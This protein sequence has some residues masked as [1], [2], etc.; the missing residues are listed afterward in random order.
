[1]ATTEIP[2]RETQHR[3][4]DIPP[5]EPGDCLDQPTFHERYA[6]MAEHVRAELVEGIVYMPSPAKCD[7][8]EGQSDVLGWLVYYKA[9]TDGTRSIDNATIILGEENELQPDGGLML[10]PECGGRA[11]LND[12]GYLVGGPELLAEIA[13]STAAYDLHAKRRAYERAGV[14]EYIVVV[15]RQRRVIWFVREHGRFME[16]QPAPDGILRSRFFP[17]LWLDSQ[18]LLEGRTR[19]VY[20]V[21]QQGLASPDHHEFVK[22]LAAARQP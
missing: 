10:L 13:S 11:R 3:F 1:M 2:T 7:H 8:G 21:L 20:E 4:D 17:G 19:R 6:A 16:L 5:L 18:A 22:K 12:K 9:H 15:L 14:Q